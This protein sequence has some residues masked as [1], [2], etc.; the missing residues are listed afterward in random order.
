MQQ[1]SD[2]S[3]NRIGL[4]FLLLGGLA[5]FLICGAISVGIYLDIFG[6]KAAGTLTNIAYDEGRS[7]NP[8]T[9]QITF[10]TADGEEVS[11]HPWQGQ[12]WF[13][14]NDLLRMGDDPSARFN[15][16]DVRYLESYPKLAKVSLALKLEYANRLIWLFWSGVTLLA[17]IISRRKKSI[18]IDLSKRNQ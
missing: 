13:Q 5:T 17:G 7:D 9:P 4:V 3:V 10:T 18:T 2:K 1:T 8:F 15:D 12:Q 11:F 6:E 16:V 14:W